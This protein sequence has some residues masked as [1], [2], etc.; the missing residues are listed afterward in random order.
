MPGRLFYAQAEGVTNTNNV[1]IAYVGSSS[2][3]NCLPCIR[4]VL[5]GQKVTPAEDTCSYELIRAVKVAGGSPTAVTPRPAFPGGTTLIA[6][7]AEAF[8]AQL[9]DGS[10][11]NLTAG[12]T[13]IDI[14]LHKKAT[15]EWVAP[16]DGEIW[17]LMAALNG[18]A[19]VSDTPSTT[20]WAVDACLAYLE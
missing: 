12:V 5:I 15:I 1:S 8:Q 13:M 14:D 17:S 18:I 20:A 4:S 19:L 9:T 16:T 11:G 6:A 10:A 7:S 2:T 3:F